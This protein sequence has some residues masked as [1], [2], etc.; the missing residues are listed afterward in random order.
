[1]R[2]SLVSSCL[3]A[4]RLC[5][6]SSD[7]LRPWSALWEF[8]SRCRH[9]HGES[10][11]SQLPS[12]RYPNPPCQDSLVARAFLSMKQTGSTVR[13]HAIA[14][15]ASFGAGRAIIAS[16]GGSSLALSLRCWSGLLSFDVGHSI[17]KLFRGKA[18]PATSYAIARGI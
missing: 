3:T 16:A 18:C 8:S 11:S 2:L 14:G 9:L 5:P 1:M 15:S 6:R 17:Y 10:L 7:V 4:L 12:T 13:A